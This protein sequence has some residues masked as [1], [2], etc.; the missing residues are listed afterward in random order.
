MTSSLD[1]RKI[2]IAGGSGFLGVSLAHHLTG[3]GGSV[4]ILSRNA[5]RVMF[6]SQSRIPRRHYLQVTDEDYE[7]AL[8]NPVQQDHAM[9][10]NESHASSQEVKKTRECES[11]R[12]SASDSVGDT[13]LEPVTSAV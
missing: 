5:P 6:T 3:L 13:G 10:R 4:V 12:I 7:K 9:P 1:Q 11:L 2:V 8:H